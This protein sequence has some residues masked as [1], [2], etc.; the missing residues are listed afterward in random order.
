[1]LEQEI[2][3]TVFDENMKNGHLLEIA[4]I[5]N[6]IS[7]DDLFAAIGNGETTLSKVTSKIKKQAEENDISL[8]QVKRKAIIKMKYP[9]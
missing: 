9:A 4:K 1:M 5:L 2:T 7:V 8:Y 6:Y 3:K